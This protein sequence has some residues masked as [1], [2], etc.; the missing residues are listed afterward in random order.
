MPQG[1]AAPKPVETFSNRLAF[2]FAAMGAAVGLG[3]V[4]Q[5][6]YMVGENGGA[7]F[8]LVYLAALALVAAPIFVA[9]TMLGRHGAASP[10]EALRRVA[11]E[12]GVSARG[13]GIVGW[14]GL[15]ASILVLSFYSVIAGW[16]L[17][18]ALK[19]AGGAFV[20]QDTAGIVALFDALRADPLEMALWH[21]LFMGLTVAIVRRG[22]RGGIEWAA[23]WMMPALIALLVI[24]VAYGAL[25]GEFTRTVAWMFRPDWSALTPGIVLSA[26]G[27]A[28]F[29]LGVGVGAVM[30]YGAY[31]GRDV[32]LPRA[33]AMVVGA[34]T[35]V[36][37]LAGFA[38]FPVVFQQGL[39]PA[40]GPG[41]L[42]VTL[43]NAFADMVAGRWV[44]LLF[45]VFMAL[46][47]LTSAL[48]LMS[49]T[50][51]RLEE[52]GL[53]RSAATGI[54]G[55]AIWLAGFATLLSFNLLSD[56]RPLAALGF[57]DMRLFELIRD[58]ILNLLLPLGG[59][60]FALAA[61]WLLPE[62]VRAAEFGGRRRVYLAWRFAVRYV[63]PVGVLAVFA[64]FIL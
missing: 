41:L 61:G 20:G 47:A 24:L 38:V 51:A 42:F 23:S 50:V 26:I 36:A 14:A 37:L 12:A 9:E 17:A 49:P 34:D 39:D 25:F 31:L 30:I 44:G 4:W 5:F 28:F 57:A 40:A 52:R 27:T 60:A 18:Y 11:R 53:S 10:P 6:P 19:A 56:F 46:A 62:P 15:I 55:L 21:T 35:A 58:T 43:P 2:V 1:A 29:S 32:S 13:A 8:V 3:N 54:V 63:A 16:T 7:A 45:F 33:S 64:S 48:A 22:V 59:V